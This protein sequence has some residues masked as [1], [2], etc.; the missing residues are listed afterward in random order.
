M[1]MCTVWT[2]VAVGD[3]LMGSP[4]KH[5]P[6][7]VENEQQHH[8]I[9]VLEYEW[10][11]VHNEQQSQFSLQIQ[12]RSP[13]EYSGSSQWTNTAVWSW[14]NH[15]E[16][17]ST[18][19]YDLQGHFKDSKL[20]QNTSYCTVLLVTYMYIHAYVH[21]GVCTV[22]LYNPTYCTVCEQPT[23]DSGLLDS[24]IVYFSTLTVPQTKAQTYSRET[25]V[26]RYTYSPTFSPL[27]PYSEKPLLY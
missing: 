3:G 15:T 20:P 16:L 12:W 27:G 9:S 8:G 6:V 2:S 25:S 19:G 18:P 17:G 1:D 7:Q 14:Q 21:A 5:W 4:W 23:Q 26:I 24:V 10:Q 13:M 11:H 22:D